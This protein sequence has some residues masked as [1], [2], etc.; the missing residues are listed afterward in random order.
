[1]AGA[2]VSFSPASSGGGVHPTRLLRRPQTMKPNPNEATSGQFEKSFEK[3]TDKIESRLPFR[4]HHVLHGNIYEQQYG[5]RSEH[6]MWL[7]AQ[8]D[9]HGREKEK[10]AARQARSY[11]SEEDLSPTAMHV[12]SPQLKVAQNLQRQTYDKKILKTTAE[13]A[14]Y[15]YPE[16][17]MREKQV[18]RWKLIAVWSIV[19]V[20]TLTGLRHWGES[21]RTAG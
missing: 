10:P 13:P 14:A 8:E 21:T 11:F 7:E 12:R 3:M 19:G 2:A 16:M 9:L 18:R 5:D 17:T 4:Q 15:Y 1:M 20:G 6:D